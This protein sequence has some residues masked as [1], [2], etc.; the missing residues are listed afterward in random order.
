MSD[1]S[2]EPSG[3]ARVFVPVLALVAIAGLIKGVL[4][5]RS[6]RSLSRD[7]HT[8]SAEGHPS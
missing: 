7:D 3:F 1:R 4:G 8:E 5:L 6:R 2:A